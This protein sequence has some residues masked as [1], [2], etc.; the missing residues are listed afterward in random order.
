MRLIRSL[1]NAIL[2]LTVIGFAVWGALAL[3][4]RAPFDA[5]VRIGCA[6]LWLAAMIGVL[7]G[8]AKGRRREALLG[9]AVAIMAILGWWS[10]LLPTN[11]AD[12]APDVA[13]MVRGTMDGDI[14]TLTDARDFDWRSESDFTPQ[15]ETRRYDLAKLVSVDLIAGHWMG[16]A[17]AHTMVSFGFSDGRFLI[18]SIEM[19]LKKNQVFSALGGLFKTAELVTLA[20]DER[21]MIRL[22]SNLRQE[23][24]RLYR[25][26]TSPDVA[27]EVLRTYVDEANDLAEHPRWYNT[28]TT[29]CTTVVFHI[30]KAVAPDMSFDWRVLASGFLPDFAYDHGALDRSLPFAETRE[31]SKISLRARAADKEP[32]AQFSQAIRTHIPGV[33]P[34]R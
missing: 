20:G 13:R 1:L 14:L 31:R 23:D 5:P 18:W 12:W 7:V 28:L 6:A 30:A 19:R 34:A 2:V 3:W 32:S 11:E 25:L 26:N 22:R 21:D 33:A 10:T 15:W 9:L 8:R 27:R 17:I 16:E 24:V 4:F 29:N